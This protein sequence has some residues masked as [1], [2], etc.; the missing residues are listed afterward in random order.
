MALETIVRLFTLIPK[1]CSF[2]LEMRQM[3]PSSTPIKLALLYFEVVHLLFNISLLGS[4]LVKPTPEWLRAVGMGDPGDDT[5][6]GGTIPT[7]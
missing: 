7:T 2:L 5:I 6:D 3:D 4:K 1:T